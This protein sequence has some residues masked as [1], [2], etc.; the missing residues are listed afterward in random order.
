M[1]KALHNKKTKPMT[2]TQ[3][4]GKKDIGFHA[5]ATITIIQEPNF[6]SFGIQRIK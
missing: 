2:T 1:L 4:I 6:D 5:L 3:K